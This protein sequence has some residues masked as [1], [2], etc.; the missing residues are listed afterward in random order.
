MPKPPEPTAK[1]KAKEVE[2]KKEVKVVPPAH[3]N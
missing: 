3:Q 2:K 1:S